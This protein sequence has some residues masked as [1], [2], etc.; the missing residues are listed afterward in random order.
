MAQPAAAFALDGGDPRLSG[1][2]RLTER[3]LHDPLITFE[4]YVYFAKLER[5]YEKS[6]PSSGQYTSL[7]SVLT[8][9]TAT[10]TVDISSLAADG[11]ATKAT[12]AG[13]AS[14]SSALV[15]DD[16]WH[17]ASR[18]MR[19]ATWGAVFYLITTDVL[20]PYSVPWALSQMGYGPGAVLYTIFGAL[21][22]YTGYQ[23]WRM[24]LLLDSS[25]Y[26]L[27]SFGTIAFRIYG[28][29]A[30]HIVNVLQTLQLIFNVGLIVISNG[31]GLYQIQPKI[32]YVVCC[33]IW[34]VLGMVLG[35]VRT[36][37]RMG[38]LANVAIWINV[39]VMILTM[40]MVTRSSPNYTASLNSN[41]RGEDDG[42]IR[43]Y[44]SAPP[45]SEGFKTG[46]SGLMQAVYSYGGQLIFCEFISEMRR[47]HDFW[48]AL[49]IAEAFITA[50]YLFFGI[51]V[52]S[53]HGQ[54]VINPAYQ[55]L[56]SQVALK[57]GNILG[58]TSA[59]L[60]AAL[61]SN[62]GIKVIYSNVLVEVFRAPPLSS[63][64]GKLL[65]VALVPLY[66]SLAFLLAASIPNFPYLS[67]LVAAVCIL[68]FTY[69]F[70]P[71]LMLGADIQYHAIQE[72]EGFDPRTG[73]TTR[74]DGGWTRWKR[75]I[76][77]YWYVNAWNLVLGLGALCTAGLG[78]YASVE[79]LRAAFAVGR[80]TSFSCKGPLGSG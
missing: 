64:V 55:G 78:V 9:T 41:G 66:W 20:G 68:Q 57:A 61:Y 70:P 6:L 43:T 17:N 15:T 63:R 53:F 60:A 73:T 56:S 32:C 49:V 71:L 39:A 27:S 44:G 21:A 37:Q 72:G 59:L 7:K 35:Q 46:I 30:R 62:I 54:Y 11:G 4:E 13:D 50:V 69:T 48:K 51:F 19:T 47:P 33:V 18:A 38:W 25:R 1:T 31:Q 36:L 14:A 40:A 28:S 74:R 79:G 2:T 22:G 26:P 80:S 42:P 52:Y 8:R 3:K 58:L 65:W 10:R 23:I 29:W 76:K 45:Y 24:F 16:E 12:E 77:T 75:G 5:E 67:G 34:T